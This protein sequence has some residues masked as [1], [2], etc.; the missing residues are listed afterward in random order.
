[1]AEHG[2]VSSVLLRL[3]DSWPLGAAAREFARAGV[4]IFPC[5]PN[6]KRPL[7]HGGFH[8]ATTDFSQVQTWWDQIPNANIGLPTGQPSGVVVV[9]VDLHE[10]VNG[11]D[12]INRAYEAGRL[13]QWEVVTRTPSGGAHLIYPATPATQQRSWQAARAGVDFRGDGGYIIVPPSYRRIDGQQHHYR[14]DQVNNGPAIAVDAQ[15]LRDF[16]DPRPAVPAPESRG[17]RRTPN[18]AALADRVASLREGERNL[19]L[20]KAACRLAE[21]GTPP[22]EALHVLGAAAG[23]AGLGQREISRTV[24]SAYHNVHGGGARQRTTVGDQQRSFS[25]ASTGPSRPPVYRVM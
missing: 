19:G 13:G 5:A 20:F 4:P 8:D 11:Y 18:I 10:K 14:L 1:M 22:G 12:A 17:T 24:Q 2:A 15:G 6:G 23:Q 3:A 7:T 21:N 9:D 25:P 16:L